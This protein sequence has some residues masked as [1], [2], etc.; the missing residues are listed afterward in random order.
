MPAP[1][2]PSPETNSV[3]FV[4]DDDAGVRL[5]LQSLLQSVGLKVDAFSSAAEFLAHRMPAM[6]AN[7]RVASMP[8]L[9]AV[10]LLSYFGLQRRAWQQGGADK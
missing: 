1:S 5:S 2:K 6:T 9:L 3:V 10:I 7:T 4:I 8:F